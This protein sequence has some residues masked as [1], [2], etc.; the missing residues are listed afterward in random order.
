MDDKQFDRL[1]AAVS[2]ITTRRGIV[3]LIAA[4]PLCGWLASCLRDGE[5]VEGKGRGKKGQGKD[6]G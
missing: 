5:E 3:Q 2:T 4:L 6:R 1:T